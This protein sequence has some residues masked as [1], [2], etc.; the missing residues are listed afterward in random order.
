MFRFVALNRSIIE[1]ILNVFRDFSKVGLGTRVSGGRNP[2]IQV[3]TLEY[4][5]RCMERCMGYKKMII[6]NK[7]LKGC[8]GS[9]DLWVPSS[10]NLEE[11]QDWSW[12]RQGMI[13]PNY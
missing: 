7:L 11:H 3:K 1:E 10:E 4:R 9:L 5:A 12:L 8:V 6:S 2:I 13:V